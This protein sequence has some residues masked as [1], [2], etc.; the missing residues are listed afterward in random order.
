MA[1]PESPHYLIVYDN[2]TSESVLASVMTSMIPRPPKTTDVSDCSHLLPPFL[3]PNSK[4]T[5]EHE[6]Q[7]HKGYLTLVNGSF[8]FSFK[9]HVN[10]KKEDWGVPLPNL[11][12]T[13]TDLCA[14]GILLPGHG[15]HSFVRPSSSSLTTLTLWLTSSVPSIFIVTVLHPSSELSCGCSPWPG[16]LVSKLL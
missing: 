15:A 8:R 6:G 16:G 4:V 14:E 13:W 2:G 3:R 7:Y 5:Y 12:Q 1:N 9:S 11:P 10:K